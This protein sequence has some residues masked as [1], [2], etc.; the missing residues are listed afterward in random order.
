MAID[1][2]TV[3]REAQK[4]A[5]KGQ[6]DKAIAEWRKLVKEADDNRDL[7]NIYNTIG[8]LCLKK[9][10]KS[11]AADAYMRAADLLAEEGI[12]N[13]AIAVYKKVLNI[14]PDKIE[15]NLALGDLYASKGLSGNALENYKL[16]ADHYKKKNSMAKALGIYQKMADLNPANVAFRVKLAEMYIKEGM[17]KEAVKAYLDA[18]DQHVAKDAFQDARQMFEKVLALDAANT[19]VY[20]K[21][22]ILYFKEGKFDEARKS[23]KRAFEKDPENQEL[24]DLYLEA[25]TK[26]G[27]GNDAEDIYRKQL[28]LDPSRFDLHEKIYQICINKQE[29]DRALP[30]AVV[31]AEHKAESM[32]FSG[33]GEILRELIA[34]SSDPLAAA[35][36]LGDLFVKHQRGTD[37]ARELIQAADALIS[38]NS[39]DDAR[40]VL[41]RA[42]LI[43]P[44]L[45]EVKE[46]IDGLA[47]SAAAA[48]KRKGAPAPAAAPV[49]FAEEAPSEA[50]E[51]LGIPEVP[52]PEET[53]PEAG[54]EAEDPAVI[55]AL[56]EV[57][58][59]I[60]YGLGSKA[61][62]QLEGVV[63]RFPDSPQ[64]R[65]R[66]LDLYREQNNTMKAVVQAL[67]LAELY[68]KR[69]QDGESRSVLRAALDLAPGNPQIMAKLGMAA[70][71]PEAEAPESIETIETIEEPES[72][73]S[74]AEVTEL[75]IPGMEG[76]ELETPAEAMPEEIEVPEEAPEAYEEP[77][78]PAARR[79]KAA[80]VPEEVEEVSFGEEA[81]FEEPEEEA[82][83]APK[84]RAPAPP[85]PVEKE[86][87][88]AKPSARAASDS[89]IAEIFSEAEFYYQQGLFD[90][91]RKHYEKI[92]ELRPG[93]QR[94]LDRVV[95]ITREKEEYHEFSRLAEAV[96]GLESLVEAGPAAEANVTSSDV[97]SVKSLMHEITRMK[98]GEKPAPA[99][100]KPAKAPPKAP[101]PPPPARRE[102]VIEESFADLAMELKSAPRRPAAA[103][104]RTEEPE[105]SFADLE[106]G[107]K[108]KAGRAARKPSR[109]EPE[110]SF[111]DLDSDLRAGTRSAPP[112]PSPKTAPAPDDSSD[113]FDLAA[114]LR[115]ELSTAPSQKTAATAH[116][117]SLDEIFEEFKKGVEAHEK[118]EDEDTHYN[119][120]VAYREMGLLDDAISEFNMTN[121]GE[122]KFIQSRYMLGLCYLE[123]GDYETA[124]TEI[125]NALGYSYS[126]GEA[127]EERTGMH[128]DLGL[129][130][131][132]VGNDKAALEELQKVYDLDPAYREVETKIQEL[133]QGDFVSMDSIKEDIEKEISFKFLEEGARIEREE[134][135]KKT[136]K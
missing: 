113:F 123:K 50:I 64:V 20:H 104:P 77:A 76:L 33:A 17:N 92:L 97:D 13:K 107:L 126:F 78:E 68:E 5:G 46:K 19:E 14:D 109:E 133:Q 132:G 118:K 70:E 3:I 39:L 110:E 72:I 130:F 90:E 10:S 128:Y 9:N 28:S 27:R 32:D 60:K 125:Q 52:A 88:F 87:F 81:L 99:A 43:A 91:A 48:P 119:L 45:D 11:E 37:G 53:A 71:E 106:V 47:A 30:E 35:A 51:E 66:L 93:D 42:A 55:E 26:A 69:G 8:D 85:P 98:K 102:E 29:Y 121:E 127:S 6:F 4:L 122:P 67:M 73:E 108:G 57:D 25:L 79:P 84:R 101:E 115:D 2:N 94:A 23:L 116:E 131:Q 22:G 21:A 41:G 100:K 16:V 74:L 86:V 103:P 12:E 31:L 7:S 24:V 40:E 96:E 129:A 136:K 18:S 82:P 124:I 112:A 83:P 49:S 56:T 80:P 1:K 65:T 114:E 89:E 15:V 95:E 36:A 120:G 58:V 62:E 117:Q 111:A 34:L 38:R 59:L 54:E 61:V 134:K 105:E 135:T 75:E 44:D 63:R